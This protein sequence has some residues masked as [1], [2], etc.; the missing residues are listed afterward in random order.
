MS[1]ESA[2]SIII[3]VYNGA[4][5][6]AEAVAS[7]SGQN[8]PPGEIVV[9]DDG[10]TDATAAVAETLGSTIRYAYQANQ[11]PAAARNHGLRLAGGRIIGFLDVDDL[12]QPDGMAALWNRLHEDGE[13]GIVKGLTQV[14]Q[15][16]PGGGFRPRGG[17]FLFW[18]LGGTLFRRE[19]F[20]S[21]G[22]FDE[23]LRFAEDIDWFLRARDAG[24]GFEVLDQ[25]T[26][27]HRRHGGNITEGRTP[28]ELN[29]L[30]VVKASLDR[31]RDVGP[32]PTK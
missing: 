15:S 18:N 11:G 28:G 12:W 19:V 2:V 26:Q 8:P 13:L 4:S 30:R 16:V 21:V 1:T 29:I 27:C 20:S 7:L 31:R 32:K 23:G 24:V 14:L 25:V 9:V 6:L 17:P 10:S 22:P 5:F 3:P